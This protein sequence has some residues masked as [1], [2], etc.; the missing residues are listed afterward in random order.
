MEHREEA[1]AMVAEAAGEPTNKTA[2]LLRTFLFIKKNN[3]KL[4]SII[5]HACLFCYFAI[6]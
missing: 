4:H 5:H 6:R 3:K 2:H 1:E